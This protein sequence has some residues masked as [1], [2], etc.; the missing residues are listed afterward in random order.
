ME[1]FHILTDI[2]FGEKSLERLSQIDSKKA[3]IVTDPFI[4]KSD[5]IRNIVKPLERGGIAYE[6]F[7]EVVP[8]PPISKVV[9]GVKAYQESGCDTIIGVGGGS[10]M[11]LSKS[12]RKMSESMNEGKH[13]RLICIPTTSGT[14]SEVTSFAVISDPDHQRKIPLVSDDMS[15]DEA[16]LDA[17]LVRSVPAGVTADTGMDV[18]THA[19]EAYVSTKHNDFSGA[20]A[21]KAV[22]IVGQYLCRSYSDSNDKHAREKIRFSGAESRNGASAR[23]PLPYSAWA[24]ECDASSDCHRIQCRCVQPHQEP[25]SDQR[26]GCREILQHRDHARP[27]QLQSG[28]DH[29]LSLQLYALHVGEHGHPPASLRRSEDFKRGV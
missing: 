13:I 8:D 27:V 12:I 18:L 24:R 4:V 1:H 2:Y 3:F 23:C 7:T 11:D 22:E 20:L 26:S 9:A 28:H 14:G 21:E 5:A 15:P 10:A 29:S 6:V 17:V 25:G 19:V 16:I